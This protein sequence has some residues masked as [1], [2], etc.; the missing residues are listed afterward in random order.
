MKLKRINVSRRSEYFNFYPACVCLCVFTLGFSGCT[1]RTGNPGANSTYVTPTVDRDPEEAPSGVSRFDW[2]RLAQ[3]MGLRGSERTPFDRLKSAN[4][5][6]KRQFIASGNG[7]Y[8]RMGG[9]SFPGGNLSFPGGNFTYPS[10]MTFPAGGNLSFPTGGQRW[11]MGGGNQSMPYYGN[12]SFP[13]MG[14]GT[15]GQGRFIPPR[16][17]GS[18]GLPLNSPNITYGRGFPRF[19]GGRANSTYPNR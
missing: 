19:P 6:P 2:L 17:A 13:A 1:E 16:G 12:S 15:Y 8:P 4:R 11:R 14:N 18:R 3:R 5:R 7:S 10:G 9:T